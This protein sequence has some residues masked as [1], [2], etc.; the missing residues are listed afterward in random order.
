[1]HSTL[2]AH[3]LSDALAASVVESDDSISSHVRAHAGDCSICRAEIVDYQRIVEVLT[4][5]HPAQDADNSDHLTVEEL[6]SY[7]ELPSDDPIRVGL[8]RHIQACGRCTKGALTLCVRASTHNV[9]SSTARW[10]YSNSKLND[11]TWSVLW[12]ALE[13]HR[14]ALVI[15]A[16][17]L[18][19]L[20]SFST[21]LA[22]GGTTPEFVGAPLSVYQDDKMMYFTSTS[23]MEIGGFATSARRA[24]PFEGLQIRETVDRQYQVLWEP[25]P[26]AIE[27]ELRIY[28]FAGGESRVAFSQIAM[29]PRVMI[30]GHLLGSGGRFEWE[31][32]GKTFDE[33]VFVAKGGFVIQIVSGHS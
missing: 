28:S 1:M 11:D 10:N 30:P 23:N 3:P 5:Y 27:Y 22:M 21:W 20:S 4:S 2:T 18:V 16:V 29:V 33:V 12:R 31:L 17:L 9:G 8:H 15:G 13:G 19:A 6:R 32:R 24:T 25:V 26:G 14:Y 7:I